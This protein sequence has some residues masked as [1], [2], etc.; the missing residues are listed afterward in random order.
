MDPILHG[1][2]PRAL[3]GAAR[4][5]PWAFELLQC[6]LHEKEGG[7][8]FGCESW[9]ACHKVEPSPGWRVRPLTL[10][11]GLYAPAPLIPAR[12]PSRISTAVQSLSRS[13]ESTS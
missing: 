7:V 6:A 11:L 13:A 9:G 3:R 12:R 8:P 4:R 10:S 1:P 5:Y 2:S